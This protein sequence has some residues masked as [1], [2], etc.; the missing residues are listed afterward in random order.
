MKILDHSPCKGC[1]FIITFEK[2]I[3]RVCPIC[4]KMNIYSEH[5]A[6]LING[7]GAEGKTIRKIRRKGMKTKTI[8]IKDKYLKEYLKNRNAEI[9]AYRNAIVLLSEN[10]A[11][12]N[13]LFW[14][15]V[16]EEFPETD[17]KNPTYHSDKDTITYRTEK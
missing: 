14:K 11:R 6:D 1:G 17:N 4:K 13:N 8:K 10:L 12:C 3:N 9:N 7:I 16:H 2:N 5:L 15:A